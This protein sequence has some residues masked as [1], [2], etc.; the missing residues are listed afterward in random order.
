MMGEL[1][2]AVDDSKNFNSKRWGQ[3]TSM[4]Q[5]DPSKIRGAESVDNLTSSEY[6]QEIASGDDGL[7]GMIVK[8]NSLANQI[9]LIESFDHLNWISGMA[10][11]VGTIQT[12]IEKDDETITTKAAT[13]KAKKDTIEAMKGHPNWSRSIS[14]IMT[15]KP[16]VT[17]D[18]A[19]QELLDYFDSNLSEI[20]KESQ[21][22]R[23]GGFELNFG[24]TSRIGKWLFIEGPGVLGEGVMTR[25]EFAKDIRHETA[26]P[27]AQENRIDELYGEYKKQ[28]QE[29]GAELEF[30]EDFIKIQ[31]EKTG[32]PPGS[33]TF[34]GVDTKAVYGKPVGISTATGA[35]MLK[36]SVIDRAARAGKPATYKY[37]EVP[38][39]GN[40]AVGNRQWIKGL[41]K[42]MTEEALDKYLNN[43]G[44]TPA[45]QTK[46]SDTKKSDTKPSGKQYKASDGKWYSEEALRNSGYTDAHFSKMESK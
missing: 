9:G 19:E 39:T 36:I 15:Q 28:L 24:G 13:E 42:D 17:E 45:A 8:T 26:D 46:K 41:H 10:N 44:K 11:E 31:D 43:I 30:A 35:P 12:S 1:A 23:G 5:K 16:G 33:Q 40:N 32:L 3:I 2:G 25:E 14:N 37:V 29:Q 34:T 7:A 18:Q 6:W 38:L 22:E 20:Y 4:L 21:D 27:E